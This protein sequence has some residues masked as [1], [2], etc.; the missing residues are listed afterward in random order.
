MVG[1]FFQ[2]CVFPPLVWMSWRSWAA[3]GGDVL[4][5]LGAG[6]DDSQSSWWDCAFAVVLFGYLFKDMFEMPDPMLLTHHFVCGL[7]ATMSLYMPVAARCFTLGT[8]ALEFGSMS[9]NVILMAEAKGC[10]AAVQ[11]ALALTSLAVV[12]FSHVVAAWLTYAMATGSDGGLIGLTLAAESPMWVRCWFVPVTPALLVLRQKCA[13]DKLVEVRGPDRRARASAR[14]RACV[15][16]HVCVRVRVRARAQARVD[17]RAHTSAR[18]SPCAGLPCYRRGCHQEGQGGVRQHTI[19][20][21]C[22]HTRARSQLI[23][24]CAS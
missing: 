19:T 23:R 7:T 5:W 20:S 1:V 4:S 9:V 17:P 12:S 8:A 22:T 24:I 2:N 6:W 3:S 18:P 11:R 16:V 13:I 21:A 14:T 15:R 10:S